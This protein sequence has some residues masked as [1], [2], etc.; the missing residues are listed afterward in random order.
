MWL[1]RI[2]SLTSRQQIVLHDCKDWKINQKEAKCERLKPTHTF[3]NAPKPASNFCVLI[4]RFTVRML[5][6]FIANFAHFIFLIFRMVQYAHTCICFKVDCS[7]FETTR[8]ELKKTA[9]V[10][11]CCFVVFCL[12]CHRLW[13]DEEKKLHRSLFDRKHSSSSSSLLF[14]LLLL[15]Y[16]SISERVCVC[17][18]VFRSFLLFRW[19]VCI[20]MLYWFL[21][22][23]VC[24]LLFF[25]SLCFSPFSSLSFLFFFATH[26]Y[27]RIFSI[28]SLGLFVRS[29]VFLC[30]KFSR[31]SDTWLETR[32]LCSTH[33]KR[34]KVWLK[35][36]RLQSRRLFCR[37]GGG[38][39]V[40]FTGPHCVLTVNNVRSFVRSPLLLFYCFA[41]CRE[42][43]YESVS[44]YTP[45]TSNNK[46]VNNNFIAV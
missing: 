31:G 39:F 24:L 33:T 38:F 27:T 45:F 3:Y 29:F 35:G 22:T 42:F 16:R 2:E 9:L 10:E 18:C 23:V 13:L 6:F 46:I 30:S 44:V 12:C 19:C 28:H 43:E 37:C 26:F 4:Y 32:V 1:P 40:G 11:C 34:Q 41:V 5:L 21:T 14:I 15:F 7:A 8:R 36:R 25:P 17:E 20:F